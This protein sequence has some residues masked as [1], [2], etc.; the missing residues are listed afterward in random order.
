VRILLTYEYPFHKKG[1][2]GGQ[3]IVRDF[4]NALSYKGYE[5]IIS[6]LGDDELNLKTSNSNI[7]YEFTYKYKIGISSFIY[8]TLSSIKLINKYKPDLVL[9]FTSE[10]AILGCYCK[11]MKIPFYIYVAAPRIPIFK[12]RKPIISLLNIRYHFPLFLQYIGSKF[13]SS[14][15]TISEFISEELIQNWN[16]SKQNIGTIGCGVSDVIISYP[17]KDD[18]FKRNINFA[19]TGR[20]MFSHKPVNLLSNSI[21]KF[22][23]S[24]WHIIGTGEDLNDL[25]KIIY[26]LNLLDKVYFHSTLT[27]YEICKLYDN[28]SIVILPSYHESFFI[29]A[30]EAIALNKILVTNKVANLEKIF[31]K[32]E[33][34]IFS[35]DVSNASYEYAIRKAIS[36][37]NK[38]NSIDLNKASQFVKENFNWNKVVN[39]FENYII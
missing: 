32:F 12:I 35:E 13:S 31:S 16:I 5:V 14:N 3:Q 6:C 7:K 27:S 17:I 26:N 38:N 37:A 21:S 4:S 33:T 39:N 9:S 25:K 18:I 19:T 20:I 30:Y 24:E 1:Y 36:I 11:V 34:V 10:A 15:L 23:F 28:V 22:H 29:T 2:G 8:S